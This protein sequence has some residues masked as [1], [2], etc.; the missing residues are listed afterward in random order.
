MWQIV[1]NSICCCGYLDIAKL[2]L[3]ELVASSC[4][5]LQSC[6]TVASSVVRYG[7]RWFCIYI[8]IYICIEMN[9]YE[10]LL[11]FMEKHWGT[12]PVR[13]PASSRRRRQ[14]YEDC[15]SAALCSAQYWPLFTT[16]HSTALATH[17][18]ITLLE[19]RH[20]LT[21]HVR[22]IH[23]PLVELT[24]VPYQ[25]FSRRENH[26]MTFPAW[27]KREV[28]LDSYWKPLRSFSCP[29]SRSPSNP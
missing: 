28:V 27:V 15:L 8:Y 24:K 16:H 22:V 20:W 10:L 17:V 9:S 26:P 7:S 29:S 4:V 21:G 6:N 25:I 11:V 1:L 13:R 18:C 14:Q 2:A 23:G 5:S 12:W 19:L 3:K